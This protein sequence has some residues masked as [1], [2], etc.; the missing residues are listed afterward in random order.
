MNTSSGNPFNY[1]S[2]MAKNNGLMPNSSSRMALDNLLRRELKVSDPNDAKQIAEALL[3]RY[4][5]NPRAVAINKEAEGVPFLLA[6]GTPMPLQQAPTSSDA[7]MQQAINDVERDLQELTTNSILKDVTPELEGWAMAVRSAIQE[8]VNSA[9][10]ALDPRQRDK[11][12]GIRRTLGDYARLARLVGALTPTMSLIYRKFA[13]SLDEVASV[14]FVMMGEALSNVGFGGR[15]LL[16]APYSELQ[17]RRDAVIYALRNLVGATQE[18]YAPNEWPR[19]IDAYRQLFQRLEEQGQGDLRALLVE[20]ELSRVMDALIQRS[21]QG[22][23]AGLRQLGATA[24][25]DVERLRRLVIVGKNL[26]Y[27]AAPPLTAFLEALQLFV[28]GFEP[29]GGFRLLRIA[30][31]PILFYG[32][33]GMS[34]FDEAE[35]RLLRL[36]IERNQL[37]DKLDCYLQCGCTSK[38]VL[39]QIVLDKI[40][41][42]L[43]RAIDLYAV[44]TQDTNDPLKKS[45]EKRAVAYSYIVDVFLF[46]TQS[47]GTPQRGRGLLENDT[48]S[49]SDSLLPGEQG[50][51]QQY[52]NHLIYQSCLQIRK[53]L[54]VS[55]GN[56]E[57][58]DNQVLAAL[59]D[60]DKTIRDLVC[61]ELQ[62]QK[63]MEGRWENLVQT[64]APSCI[65]FRN[66]RWN[67][68]NNNHSVSG[69]F[70][71]MNSLINRAL[72]RALGK[73]ED[74]NPID[75]EVKFE[76]P[77]NYE[78]SLKIVA[79]K[80]SPKLGESAQNLAEDFDDLVN[81][82]PLTEP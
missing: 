21:G 35:E 73:Q 78:E 75:L 6:S 72:Q 46:P 1:S 33:Y 71:V 4:K 2:A 82:N 17:V 55:S 23:V 37:A 51:S 69:V 63:D 20:G 13:Q 44:G 53:D 28:D 60:N 59:P 68:S 12:F 42:D 25:L 48:T 36:I 50:N 62:V 49:N 56:N 16:Q 24:Q 11:T 70:N 29:S 18:A 34:A 31:P 52:L 7:E 45:P 54:Y 67:N 26:I 47:Q 14:L 61:Q 19:G 43:D 9:R 30:R 5:N 66:V 10:F 40:L 64:M 22:S 65:P 39:C 41:Y 77:S 80:L 8:G 38:T 81:D 79:D 76:L 57:P 3:N 32:L 74:D 58:N 27:P 15:Y